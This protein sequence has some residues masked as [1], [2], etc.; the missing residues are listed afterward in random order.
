M[1]YRKDSIIK[2]MYLKKSGKNLILKRAEEN[3]AEEMLRYINIVGGESDN[4]LF[5]KNEFHL[6]VEQEKNHIN[7]VNSDTNTLMILGIIDD[8][9]ISVSQISGSSRK[10]I[11]HNS[12]LSI[13]IKKEYWNMGVGSAVMEELINFARKNGAKNINLGVRAGN[14]NAIK[15]YEKFGFKKIGIHK[16]CIN[17]DGVFHDEILMDLNL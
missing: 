14:E 16:N 11:A 9:I 5:G 7:N 15:L 8:K 4:L 6:T 10:R 1:E 3:D 2:E 13:S 12:E 17:V